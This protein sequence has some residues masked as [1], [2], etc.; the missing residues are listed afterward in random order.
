MNNEQELKFNNLIGEIEEIILI[1]APKIK[2]EA[3]KIEKSEFFDMEGLKKINMALDLLR[4]QY[5]HFRNQLFAIDKAKAEEEIKDMVKKR[6]QLDINYIQDLL[7]ADRNNCE[8]SG[9]FQ[10]TI[11]NNR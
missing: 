9:L 6:K 4:K 5:I 3:R 1:K 7:D 2:N 8:L 11:R 10:H